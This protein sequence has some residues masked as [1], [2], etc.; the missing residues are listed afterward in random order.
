MASITTHSSP[1]Y[2]SDQPTY[3]NNKDAVYVLPNDSIEHARL[4]EQA[5][6]ISAIMSDNI[7][8]SPIPTTVKNAKMLDV[9]CGTGII[10]DLLG[11][12]FPKA[13]VY[14]LDISPVPTHVR[15]NHPE[16]VS[17]LQ[18]NVTADNP[19]QW[20]RQENRTSPFS[21]AAYG[22]FDFVF[23]RL[24]V[25]GMTNWPA[26]I[27]KVWALLKPNSG[28]IE[29]HDLDF[30]WYDK[31]DQVISDSWKWLQAV[32]AAAAEDDMDWSCGS[33]LPQWLKE[34]GFEDIT[35][36]KYRLPHGAISGR[37]DAEKA[38]G[39]FIARSQPGLVLQFLPKMLKPKG[40]SEELIQ[41]LNEEML[42]CFEVTEEKYWIMS[43][44][45]GRRNGERL[46]KM[47]DNAG[48]LFDI[49]G[50]VAKTGALFKALK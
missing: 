36:R 39:E 22:D 8:H 26:Y 33:K 32:K 27:A 31:N 13:E 45:T 2:S 11:S 12:R 43:V 40:Y 28:Y 21:N 42:K 5:K 48:T 38:F 25:C 6:H 49:S 3:H 4:E 15:A 16:N 35:V 1:A 19:G 29:L 20:L 24:L 44:V 50:L 37:T 17:F 30:T 41:E 9:G 7:I 46:K 47:N 23:S 10:T 18:G 34:A 14:G